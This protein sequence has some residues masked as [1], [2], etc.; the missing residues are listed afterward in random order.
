M[1]TK[2][3]EH[4]EETR[5]TIFIVQR[6][7]EQKGDNLNGIRGYSM[8]QS[9]VSI[10]LFILM[11]ACFN[12]I[13]QINGVSSIIY[14]PGIILIACLHL[15][16]K[17]RRMI[18]GVYVFV[19]L[20]LFLIYH[21]YMVNGLL[22]TL[23]H[24]I[25]QIGIHTGVMIP[26][27]TIQ[28][29]V[30]MHAIA[31]NSIFVYIGLFISVASY[32]L[33]ATAQALYIWFIVI[34]LFIIQA[35]LQTEAHLY[36]NV[37]LVFLSLYLTFISMNS[38]KMTIGS[39]K[40]NI[41]NS[42]TFILFVVTVI[43]S[44]TLFLVKP[45]DQYEKNVLFTLIKDKS[46]Q[47]IQDVRFERNKTNTFTAGD[48]TRLDELELREDVALEVT[49]ET[50]SSMYL[51]GFTGGVYSSEKWLELLPETKYEHR[52]LF[53]W[54]NQED[55][56]PF[57]QLHR[58]RQLVADKELSQQM[59]VV[60]R[61]V[62]AN[63]KYFYTPY[64]LITNP[65]ELNSANVWSDQVMG[66]PKVF[67]E[68]EYAFTSHTNL[69]KSYPTLATHLY[70]LIEKQELSK[71]TH[72]ES[73]YNEY[74]YDVYTEIPD[75]VR[76]TLDNHIK[77]KEDL[78]E[79][80]AYER[81]IQFI[82]NY[83]YENISYTLKPGKLPNDKDF[84]LHVIEDT[85][86]GYA[87]HYATLATLMFRYFDIP[88]RY[89]EGYLVTPKDVE[90]K[91]PHEKIIV[92]GTNAHAWTEIYIDKLGWIPIE[93]TPPFY[94]TM[95]PIDLSNYPKSL[96]GTGEEAAS[97]AGMSGS[98]TKKVK[99]RE[100][101]VVI[102]DIDNE[103][104]SYSVSWV[105]LIASILAALMLLIYLSYIV[106][107]RVKLYQLK[108][109]FYESDLNDAIK[110]MFSYMMFLLH[111]DGIQERDGSIHRYVEDIR[112]KYG[113]EYASQ[114]QKVIDMNQAAIFS[115]REISSQ[116]YQFVFS[117]LSETINQV[118]KSKSPF[119]RLKMRLWHCIY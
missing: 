69:I 115:R 33:V 116:E 2:N 44:L 78:S 58:I 75:N 108:R 57:N 37:M 34:G 29:P 110:Q 114:F 97:L 49:M 41:L 60:I 77:I 64:E 96:K 31:V 56:H 82:R 94:N 9:L 98:E 6:E 80:I 25:E 52:G 79:Q 30:E 85:Q 24:F 7:L 38:E 36:V 103:S 39:R 11:M 93:M 23:N 46:R 112:K 17:K 104:K 61:N 32:Y 4:T 28:L 113:E 105:A 35:I 18:I 45:A 65:G 72:L 15:L 5:K 68:R 88:S 107:K 59:S 14:L 40:N 101:R 87:T 26:P 91:K 55:F 3:I 83:L 111:Y 118:V 109:S 70:Q 66:T 74:V 12:T 27:Y 20:V 10:L 84:L 53:Y 90:K 48:F 117:F 22:L 92:K 73:H 16:R 43:S 119:Q 86:K 50:P 67:G 102:N 95:E 19:W 76:S 42:T 106:K 100:E 54:L 13:L 71:Y 63:S 8:L 81:A 21:P 89:V 47:Y 1:S 62:H 51:R 99:D